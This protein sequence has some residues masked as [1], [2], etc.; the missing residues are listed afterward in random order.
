[1]RAMRETRQIILATVAMVA[2]FAV[3]EWA[4]TLLFP[5]MSI[6]TSHVVTTAV[7]G[8]ITAVIARVVVR[9]QARLLRAQKDTNRRLRDALSLAEH[10]RSLLESVLASVD[11][12]LVI[13]DRDRRV[14]LINDAARRLLRTGQREVESLADVSRAPQIHEAFN[15]VLEKGTRA[16]A[17]VEAQGWNGQRVLRLHAAPLRL[18]EGG[19]DGVVGAFIDIT[20]LELL[21]RVRQEFLTNVSHE[22]RTPLTS[23]AAYAETLIDGGVEDAANRMR[24]L[25]T[26][27]RNVERMRDLVSDISEL[28]LIESGAV[29]LS[30]ER[31][32]LGVLVDEVLSGLG[33]RA[34][35]HQVRLRNEVPMNCSVPADRRRLEQIL[36]NLV[37]NAIKFNRAGGEVVVSAAAQAEPDGHAQLWIKVRDTGPGIPPEHLPRVFERF[38]RVDKARSRA[39]GGTGLGLA[40]VK[41][42]TRAHGGE[43]EVFSE[44]G[45]GCE[46]IIK[47]PDPEPASAPTDLQPPDQPNVAEHAARI[48][49]V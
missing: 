5:D 19:A 7:A 49:A 48:P 32:A 22:L 33:P 11:E 39:L 44:V 42:L 43:A 46:F 29:R 25:S 24:F 36:T 37:D 34:E 16:E 13:T 23:I 21:E 40:I 27:Q 10:S 20:K 47:L 8:L 18:G 3:Y 41:H 30:P 45:R 35:R 28:S 4:K 2:V 12:G 1:M 38:Y 17:R 9:R 26:I 6:F 14:L 15:S 31:L